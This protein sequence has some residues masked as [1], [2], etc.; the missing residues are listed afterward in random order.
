MI[1]PIG[2]IGRIG[3]IGPIFFQRNVSGAIELSG[4]FLPGELEQGGAAV[5]AAVGHGTGHEA[6]DESRDIFEGDGGLASGGLTGDG[7]CQS[8]RIKAAGGGAVGGVAEVVEE[9]AQEGWDLAVG[10]EIRRK[11]VDKEGVGAEFFEAEAHAAEGGEVGLQEVEFAG[12]E[13]EGEGGEEGLGGNGFGGAAGAGFLVENALP[14][15]AVV[16]Q[17]EAFG[18]LENEI[19]GT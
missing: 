6:G 3:L 5:G 18:A 19:G 17:N 7:G 2:R 10:F 15:G 16:E 1:G 11:A 4:E 8:G 12:A 13:G 9:R 14:C